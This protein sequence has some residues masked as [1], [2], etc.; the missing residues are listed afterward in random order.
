MLVNLYVLQACPSLETKY[1]TQDPHCFCGVPSD[2]PSDYVINC[3]RDSHGPNIFKQLLLDSAASA[4]ALF[5]LFDVTII[6]TN[7]THLIFRG[8]PVTFMWN[9]TFFFELPK[10]RYLDLSYMEIFMIYAGFF[11]RIPNIEVLL[12]ND[13]LLVL[14]GLEGISYMHYSNGQKTHLY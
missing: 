6:P 7:T 3:A 4:A 10:V 13:N 14:S 9:D 1:K 12:L 8:N 2:S 11:D 5:E